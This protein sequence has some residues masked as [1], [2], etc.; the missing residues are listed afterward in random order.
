MQKILDAALGLFL[1][2]GFEQTTILDIVDHMGGLTRGAFY[3]HFK[4]KEEVLDALGDK[5][6]FENNPFDKVKQQTNLNGLEKLK[7]LIVDSNENT[8]SRKISIMS[9]Q[10]LQSPVFVKK[11]IEDSR[12]TIAPYY[13]ELIEEGVE[14][15]SIKTDHPKLLSQLIA[16][17][18][19]I[20]T[21]P[22]FY[23][24]TEDEAMEKLVFIKEITD[25]LGISI[26]DDELM[27]LVIEKA[28]EIDT[29]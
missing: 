19:G 28:E 15:G 24:S 13:Q 9:A 17:L 16:F 5:M 27:S 6:F 25:K 14:D 29:K 4:S 7:Y 1:E 21:V 22:S 8:D 11:M 23:P 20:W 12:D 2:K 3:H 26:L 18:T 10:A